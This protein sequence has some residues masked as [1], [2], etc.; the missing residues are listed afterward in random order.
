M[1]YK[2]FIAKALTIGIILNSI[3]V[4]SYANTEI[5]N[6]YQTLEG[7]Y[8]T[9]DDS[10]EGN[11]EEIE[12]F[13]NTVQDENDL[14][15]IQS[16]GDLYV[17]ENGNPILDRQGREQYKIDIV[18]SNSNLNYNN[19]FYDKPI[20]TMSIVDNGYKVESNHNQVHLC[21]NIP[22]NGNT[23]VT[24]KAKMTGISSNYSNSQ[25]VMEWW[26]DGTWGYERIPFKDGELNYM[27]N[28]PKITSTSKV[29]T[30]RIGIGKSDF[31]YGYAIFND[32]SLA[33]GDTTNLPFEEPMEQKTTV[34][35]PCQLEKVGDVAD[36]LYWDNKKGRY[37]VEK[38]IGVD[39]LPKPTGRTVETD[40]YY[41]NTQY[42]AFNNS[43]QTGSSLSYKNF[44]SL[45]NY[46]YYHYY[47]I[48]DPDKGSGV[49]IWGLHVTWRIFKTDVDSLEKFNSLINSDWRI[50]GV[51]KNS[52]IIDTEITSKLKIPTYD[53]KTYIYV[54]SENGINPTLKV[55]ID[56]LSKIAKEAVAQAESD[57]SN[58][59]ISLARMYVNMLPESLYK[60]QLQEQL[61]EIFSSDVVLD[62]KSATANLDLYIKCENI[63]QMSLNT[64]S[65]TFEDFSGI[66]DMTKENAVQIS[67]NSSLPYSLNAYL[68]TEIQNSDKSAT[69]N[70]DILNIKE[71]SESVYQ[72]FSNTT[73]KI[74]LK[75]N[76]S[77]GN[78]LMHGVDIKLKG[79][80][81]HE[82]DVYKTTIKFEAQQ[83]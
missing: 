63:L 64:N 58:Y 71:N 54:D 47:N 80:I 19:K 65:I 59:N 28:N 12:I 61:S 74:V 52:E 8:I 22:L 17:D 14:D 39:L 69:M 13:G 10:M 31:D 23:E 9:I 42:G 57:S 46:P 44:L 7:K 16:V 78:D 32:I 35:L 76:C 34:L 62:K 15:D 2:I 18:S 36:K 30:V 4:L 66:E 73:D 50:M 21:Y 72:T 75:D 49:N 41:E 1:K 55:T 82:K 51:L 11:L 60:D 26:V 25:A 45:D 20:G 5:P 37:V 38:N 43:L 70:K 33:Y 81:A 56:R 48:Y 77:A 79:G 67:I 29:L 6:R 24:V 40:T 3:S 68:P 27:I 53:G 83:K